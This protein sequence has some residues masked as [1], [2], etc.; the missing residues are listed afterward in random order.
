MAAIRQKF[1]AIPERVGSKN[2]TWLFGGPNST[3]N[4]QS[5]APPFPRQCSALEYDKHPIQEG[6][7][8]GCF[9]ATSGA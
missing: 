2:V 9:C 6:L 7:R 4:N 1:K 5:A 3:T 8:I